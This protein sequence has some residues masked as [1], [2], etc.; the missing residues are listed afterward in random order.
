MIH[1][2]LQ[3]LLRQKS[4]ILILDTKLFLPP[5]GRGK[6]ANFTKPCCVPSHPPLNNS[7]TKNGDDLWRTA[8]SNKT[9]FSI[10]IP[11]LF[12][13]P[14]GARV[15]KLILQKPVVFLLTHPLSYELWSY[16]PCSTVYK[17]TLQYKVQLSTIGRIE[18]YRKWKNKLPILSSC[19]QIPISTGLDPQTVDNGFS[20]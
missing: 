5:R 16:E 19:L 15:K 1:G 6:K 7:Q 12:F 4:D 11:K 18:R 17:F 3:P 10:S 2:K 9:K 13:Y 14:L 20:D 8:T